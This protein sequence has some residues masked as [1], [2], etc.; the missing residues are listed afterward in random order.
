MT[1]HGHIAKSFDEELRGLKDRILA[2]GGIVEKQ[3]VDGVRAYATRD[4]A[5]ANQ[6]IERDRE[7]NLN[8]LAIDETCIHL[9][10]IRQPAASDLRFICAAL[11]IVIDLERIGDLARNI[12]SRA[13]EIVGSPPLGSVVDLPET[14]NAARV[15]LKDAL[16]AF[17]D[18]NAA[19]A[20]RVLED[21]DPIDTWLKR[22]I[23]E[24]TAEMKR[25]PET[26]ESGVSMIS[27]AKYIERIADHATNLAEMVVYMVQGK[28][29][30][31]RWSRRPL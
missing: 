10:A 18:R 9:L 16:D 15:M 21:D 4:V 30:R 6:V 5:L 23:P 14:A 20:E 25:D 8:E 12:A 26:A 29:V 11:K 2:M 19:K 1:E 27:V 7:I 3:I 13:L 28:D 24:V 22:V 17:V 31:H